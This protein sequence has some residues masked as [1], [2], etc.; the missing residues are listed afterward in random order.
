M[1]S[2]IKLPLGSEN[3]SRF[4]QEREKEFLGNIAWF[5]LAVLILASLPAIYYQVWI[6]LFAPCS[7]VFFLGLVL[8]LTR[9]GLIIVAG[10]VLSFITSLFLFLI[11]WMEGKTTGAHLYFLPLI[12]VIPY[13]IDCN[14]NTQLILHILHPTIHALWIN[15]GDIPPRLPQISAEVQDLYTIFNFGFVVFLCQFFAYLIISHNTEST[16]QLRTSEKMLRTQNEELVKINQELDRFVYSISHE[17]R[18]PLASAIGLGNLIREEQDVDEIQKYNDIMV[19]NLMRLD[20]LMGDILK[21]S[22]N[23]RYEIRRDPIEFEKEIEES[24]R[25]YQYLHAGVEIRTSIQQSTDFFT[26]RYR[27]RIV[28]NNLIS[29]AFRYQ[30]PYQSPKEMHIACQVDDNRALLKVRDNGVGIAAEDQTRIFEMFY[31]AGNQM[32]HVKPGSGLGLYIAKESIQKM[33]GHI[34]VVSQIGEFTEF[35]VEIPSM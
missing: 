13:L 7:F 23:A 3:P 34:N 2:T 4:V 31:R 16:Y 26:D 5:C 6:V 29:N 27:F 17:L 15:F 20:L 11:C 28:L 9:K 33:S 30:N 35:T 32:P 18:A 19:Q 22:R 8:Y 24:I 21:Y 1:L 10:N 25:Q 14:N 12:V